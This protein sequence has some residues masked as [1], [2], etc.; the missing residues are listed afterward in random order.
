MLTTA[1]IQQ[2]I[3][4]DEQSE[5]KRFARVGEL[6]AEGVHDIL[7]SRLLYVN[8]E[9]NI[10]ED[11][12]RAN[13][14]IP[15][16][17]FMEL[18][19]QLAPYMLSFKENPIRACES[20]KDLQEQLDLYFDEIFWAEIAELIRGSDAKGF[21]YIYGY[22]NEDGRTIFQCADSMGVVEVR[23]E[24]T[25]DHCKYIIYWYIDRIAKG[26]KEIRRIQVW[27]EKDITYYV[28]DGKSGE[29]LIDKFAEVNPRPH[30]VLYNDKG[31]RMGMPLGYIPFWR[32]DNNKKQISS[33]KPIKAI[34]DDYD[35]HASALSNNLIDFDSPLYIVNGFD[36]DLDEIYQNIRTKK[37]MGIPDTDGGV[38]IKTIDIPYEARKAKLELDEKDIYKFGMGLN[39]AGLKDTNATTNLAIKTAYAGLK[40]RADRMQARLKALLRD[41][42]KV[43]LAEINEEHNT[44]YQITDVWFDFKRETMTNETEN[45]QNAKTEAETE[46][47]RITT[48]LNIALN[49]GVEQT[50]RAI[51]DVMEWDFDD[52]WGKVEAIKAEEQSTANAQAVLN[53]VVTDE[54]ASEISATSIPQ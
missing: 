29:I 24:D 34:I 35:C 4:D 2:F 44:D 27:S 14:K 1:E 36:G 31:E 52:L 18:N 42:I 3:T 48:I 22:K 12:V 28:Q 45:I 8:A 40:L 50:L 32:L 38:E 11:K 54:Q 33:L 13:T 46:Q 26:R 37:T 25:D 53:G 49:V 10:E 6:Y 47:I 51:C 16:P 15:H 41:I 30:T 17:F 43:V 23:E 19:Q 20:V 7:K 5:K 39:T 9:G 21:E